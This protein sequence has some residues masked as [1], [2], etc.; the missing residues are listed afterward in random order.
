MPL[1]LPPNATLTGILRSSLASQAESL[2]RGPQ[3]P[4]SAV[5]PVLTLS[6]DELALLFPGWAALQASPPVVERPLP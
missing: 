6:P 5:R 2:A 4:L 1:P 3:A